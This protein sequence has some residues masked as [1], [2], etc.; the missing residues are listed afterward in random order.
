MGVGDHI[1][2]RDNFDTICCHNLASYSVMMCR[3]TSFCVGFMQIDG[4]VAE[5][6]LQVWSR[7][8]HF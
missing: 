3:K 7:K 5:K 4:K 1:L 6:R 2:P 8:G